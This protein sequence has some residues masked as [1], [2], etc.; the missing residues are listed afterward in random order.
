MRQQG[1]KQNHTILAIQTTLADRF[2]A[3][4]G[5]VEILIKGDEVRVVVDGCHG[6][7]DMTLT[8]APGRDL[9]HVAALLGV[10]V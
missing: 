10:E 1:M 8:L 3:G 4:P 7:V 2:G 5:D 9:T 6:H